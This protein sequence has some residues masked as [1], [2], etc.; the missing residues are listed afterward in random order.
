MTIQ[1]QNKKETKRE[2]LNNFISLPKYRRFMVFIEISKKINLFPTKR[3]SE[4]DDNFI[5]DF[6]KK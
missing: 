4:I 6:S 1:F 3:K 5:I 2:Q